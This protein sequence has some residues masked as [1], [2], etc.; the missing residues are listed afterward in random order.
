MGNWTVSSHF[1][2]SL[3]ISYDFGH[4]VP[5]LLF[6]LVISYPVWSFRTEFGQFVPTFIFLFEIILVIS[7]PFFQ[8][9]K[10]VISYIV[11]SYPV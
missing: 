8:F 6:I 4:F 3:V 10:K 11:I 2:P 9:R 5:I 7:Y 1:V